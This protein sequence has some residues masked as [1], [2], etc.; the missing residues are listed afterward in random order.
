MRLAPRTRS[1]STV[2][3]HGATTTGMP[4]VRRRSRTIISGHDSHR[5]DS[6]GAVLTGVLESLRQIARLPE[7][8]YSHAC[9]CG[10][11]EMHVWL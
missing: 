3:L 5:C 9:E 1:P 8:V 11:P 4:R 10:H 2:A 6:C 7:V